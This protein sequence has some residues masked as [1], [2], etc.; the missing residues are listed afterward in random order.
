[1]VCGLSTYSDPIVQSQKY[2]EWLSSCR[3]NRELKYG[4][5]IQLL[6]VESGRLL[7][8]MLKGL[9]NSSNSG[10]RSFYSIELDEHHND[11]Y[12]MSTVE[13]FFTVMPVSQVGDIVLTGKSSL[14]VS[15]CLG[16]QCGSASERWGSNQ[17]HCHQVAM[18]SALLREEYDS[19][20]FDWK[21]NPGKTSSPLLLQPMPLLTALQ[22]RR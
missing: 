11:P 3:S 14:T 17:T 2:A 19:T 6:H 12:L 20:H 15:S 5:Q 4:D 13:S 9:Q 8:V 21:L 7:R 1:M 10:Q 22:H 16:S 18:G